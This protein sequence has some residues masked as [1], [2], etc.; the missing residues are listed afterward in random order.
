MTTEARPLLIHHLASISLSFYLVGALF[1]WLAAG[2]VLTLFPE[3]EA[4][5]YQMN[6]RLVLD[7]LTHPDARHW[8]LV[9]WFLVLCLL[10]F[11][12]AVNL[13]CCLGIT[14]WKRLFI[15]GKLKS[16][17]LFALHVIV[18]GILAGHLANMVVGFK[19]ERIKM[20]PGETIAL[21][22]G[23][24]LILETVHFTAD[25]SLL[26]K[27]GKESRQEM[28]R[29]RFKIAD[30]YIRVA[31][32]RDGE[33]VGSGPVHVLSPLKIGSLRVTLN[34]FL[35]AKNL[36]NHPVGAMVTVAKNPIHEAF[37]LIYGLMILCL[38]AYILTVKDN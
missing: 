16:C 12:L 38:L 4:A 32:S 13:V 26:K 29:D 31:L 36:P 15:N 1:V 33:P 20:T 18:I 5:I 10:N 7:W 19:Q 8:W 3:T 37:F 28:S 27:E 34:R 25:R 35:A 2:I 9:G 30:N 14:L 21:P 6:D 23:Y 22:N 24:S 11:F 17:L